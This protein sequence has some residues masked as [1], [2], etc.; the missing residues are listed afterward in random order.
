MGHDVLE[1]ILDGTEE[2]T[3]LPFELLKNITGNFSEER[4]IGHGG[5]GMVY[6]VTLTLYRILGTYMIL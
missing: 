4:E 6:K 3:N 2:P 5:F 1:H